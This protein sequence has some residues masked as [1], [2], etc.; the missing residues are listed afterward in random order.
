MTKTKL[1]AIQISQNTREDVKV[2]LKAFLMEYFNQENNSDGPAQYS[3]LNKAFFILC[4]G[5]IDIL[6]QMLFLSS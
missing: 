3:F 4:R 1:M 6:F 5:P 2:R